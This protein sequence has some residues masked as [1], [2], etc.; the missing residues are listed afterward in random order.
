[1][2]RQ[3]VNKT[4]K[5]L[6]I[7][8][9]APIVTELASKFGFDWLLFD[10]EH[11]CLTEAGLLANLQVTKGTQAKLIVRVPCLDK[12]LISRVLDWGADGI[13]LP[14]VS[15]GK[16]VDRCL[17]AMNYAPKG[18]RGYSSSSRSF[19]YGLSKGNG[20]GDKNDPLLIVQIENIE[21]VDNIE[22]IAGKTGV[23]VIF[24]GPSDLR[25]NLLAHGDTTD[26]DFDSAIRKVA[27]ACNSHGKTSGILVHDLSD[28]GGFQEL[29][30]RY[31]GIG[32]DLGILRKGFQGLLGVK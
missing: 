9:G 13:M 27:E 4:E 30:F 2:K 11:G 6:W 20:T 18:S 16:D 10:L 32:S 21:G 15:S 5:G 24:V 17:E 19:G 25:H 1:M 23:D 8:I 29:G 14:M 12:H 28:L 31:F 3:D 26:L 22:S 7:S